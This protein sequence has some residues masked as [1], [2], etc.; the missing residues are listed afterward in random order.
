MITLHFDLQPQFKYMNYVICTSH[1]EL[2]LM[3]IFVYSNLVIVVHSSFNQIFNLV[4]YLILILM[5]RKPF[6]GMLNK[7]Y[8]YFL[9]TECL[10]R[11]VCLQSESSNED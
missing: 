2:G 5:L 10:W 11:A 6:S 1:H 8:V 3:M 7:V 4:M 9:L